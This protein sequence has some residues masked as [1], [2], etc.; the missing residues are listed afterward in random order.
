MGDNSSATMTN[1]TTRNE[2]VKS[3]F[4][5][6]WKSNLEAL[7]SPP[8]PTGAGVP[9]NGPITGLEDEPGFPGG[10]GLPLL[11]FFPPGPV[12]PFLP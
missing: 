8:G 3:K 2:K 12:A 4:N 9:V 7:T 11:P 1:K 5:F 6:I 10:P